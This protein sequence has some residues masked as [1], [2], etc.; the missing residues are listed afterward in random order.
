MSDQQQP[1]LPPYA[2]QHP[3]PG[4]PLQKPAAGHQYYAAAHPQQQPA[5]GTAN[6]FGR[7]GLIFGVAGLAIGAIATIAIQ[8]TYRSLGFGVASFLSG[9]GSLAAFIAAAVALVLGIIGMKCIGAPHG[10]AGIAVGLGIAGVA[11]GIIGAVIA[12]LAP[13][14]Y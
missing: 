10:Q 14:F 3:R 5:P 6:I 8:A 2:G 11:G 7:V 13:L 9:F 12:L 1:Q 4:A